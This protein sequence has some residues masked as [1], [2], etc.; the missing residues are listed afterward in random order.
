MPRMCTRGLYP[1][2]E[3]PEGHSA[4]GVIL[5]RPPQTVRFDGVGE[6]G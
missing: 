6:Q 4:L 1:E 2:L 5:M 3:L